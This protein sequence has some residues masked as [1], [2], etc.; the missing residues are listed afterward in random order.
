MVPSL[1][2]AYTLRYF[3]CCLQWLGLTPDSYTRKAIESKNTTTSVGAVILIIVCDLCAVYL[4]TYSWEVD[5]NLPDML[6]IT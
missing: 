4:I 5:A 1:Y 3:H 6:V 2:S